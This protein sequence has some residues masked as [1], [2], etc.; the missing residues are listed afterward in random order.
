MSCNA[1]SKLF[2]TADSEQAYE[3]FSSEVSINHLL[4]WSREIANGMEFLG[5]K[6][7]VHGDLS[8]RNVLLTETLVAKV[9]DFGLSRVMMKYSNYIRSTQDEVT[10]QN[11]NS[12]CIAQAFIYFIFIF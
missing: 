6:K 11:S 1:F 9:G 2:S 4:K 8:A 10:T 7:I 3:N 12:Q 5:S